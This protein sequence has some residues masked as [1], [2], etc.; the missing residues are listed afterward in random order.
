[1]STHRSRYD[2][3][4]RILWILSTLFLIACGSIDP[5][6]PLDDE[7]EPI[8]TPEP[9][10]TWLGVERIEPASGV[11]SRNPVFEITFD[12]Y[13]EDDDL[14]NYDLVFLQS[15]G[16]RVR[17]FAEW[18]VSRR[19]L[20]WRPSGELIDG[21]EYQLRLNEDRLRSVTGAPPLF[22]FGAE[23]EVDGELE[24]PSPE[25]RPR[26][27][28][29]DI[30]TIIVRKC[31]SCHRDPEWLLNPLT[32]ESMIGVRADGRDQLL[33]IRRDPADSYLMHKIL[34]DY[35]LR[36][37]GIQPPVWSDAAPLTPN[38]VAAIQSWIQAGAP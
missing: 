22:R 17:G 21:L 19:T 38:E 11:I 37:Y 1:M 32:P 28:W 29:R 18:D 5:E 16:I 33:V 12:T 24:P 31:A 27:T 4:M 14:L 34:P 2:L 6:P 7:G 35:P 25:A 8:E 10:D 26:A 20:V 15:G 13:I 23:Y 3:D 36:D 30:D 9:F